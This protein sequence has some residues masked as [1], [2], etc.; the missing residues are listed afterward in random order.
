MLVVDKDSQDLTYQTSYVNYFLIL[1]RF[2]AYCLYQFFI[3]LPIFK[4]LMNSQIT[5]F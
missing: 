2:L 5:H 3:K 1:L 4:A